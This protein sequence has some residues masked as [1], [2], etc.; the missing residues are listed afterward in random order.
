MSK[1]SLVVVMIAATL[2]AGCALTSKAEPNVYRYFTPEGLDAPSPAAAG[3]MRVGTG[4]AS[5]IQLR[6]GRVTAAAYLRE[7]IAYRDSS[8]EVSYLDD[9][10]WTE[11]PDAFVRRALARVLFEERGMHQIVSGAGATIE[12]ELSAFEELRSPRH[13]ARVQVTWTL[14]DDQVVRVEETF[15]VERA[16][17]AKGAAAPSDIARALA[18]ALDEAVNR[19][20][21]RTIDVLGRAP[22]ASSAER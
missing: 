12:V 3:P 7:E 2:S 17:S 20:A 16:L 9:A 1:R 8:F 19:I 22:P 5:S 15:A 14:R 10:R 13:A 4:V 18:S 21:A 6:L 11:R